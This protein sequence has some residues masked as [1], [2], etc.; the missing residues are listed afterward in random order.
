MGN[1]SSNSTG[2]DEKVF[3]N[4]Y[5]LIDNIASGL[6]LKSNFDSLSKLAE[7]NSY[8]NDLIIL[9]SDVI[10]KHF[11]NLEVTYLAQRTEKGNVIDKQTT[12]QLIFLNKKELENLDVQSDSEMKTRKKRMCDGIAKFYIKIAHVFASIICTINPV[13]IFKDANG[14]T[15]QKSWKDKHTIPPNVGRKLYKMN[16]CDNRIKAL[17]RSSPSRGDATKIDIQPLMC[18][19]ERSSL[20]DEPGIVELMDLYFDDGYNEKNG[21]FNG[22]SKTAKEQYDKDLKTFY[23]AFTGN[24]TFDSSVLKF[25]DIKLK[26]YNKRA[27]CSES[28]KSVSVTD[29]LFIK[30]AENINNMIHHAKNKQLKLIEVL[31]ML[32]TYI[33]NP[34]T[35]AKTYRI[36]PKL[37]NQTLSSA[38]EMTRALIVD[39]Y[40]TCENDYTTGLQIYEAIVGKKII[41]T[42]IGQEITLNK[43]LR[44]LPSP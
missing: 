23:T 28:G 15:V 34:V 35:K 33:V 40:V 30:Y 11:T 8:C 16:I 25:G 3:E 17:Q 6:I 20:T 19:V 24:A 5:I 37:T 39:L 1:A 18:D 4:F 10:D 42:T 21:S 9:T 43:V 2:N 38:V 26:D 27:D 12:D 41:D 14:A 44:E 7:N 22:M 32:F 31:N 36:H 13:Y 29:K